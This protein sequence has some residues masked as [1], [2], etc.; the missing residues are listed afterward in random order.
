MNINQNH[1]TV[2]AGLFTAVAGCVAPF[3]PVAGGIIL[4]IGGLLHALKP[5][6]PQK[7]KPY[8]E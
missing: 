3:S 6:L 2:G 7:V 1:A 4:A 5:V 8:I